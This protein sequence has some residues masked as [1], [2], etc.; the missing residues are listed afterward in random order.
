MYLVRQLYYSLPDSW[1]I[2]ED[3]AERIQELEEGMEFYVAVSFILKHYLLEG[4]GKLLRL[5]D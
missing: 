4:G 5:R 1:R 2:V 3:R